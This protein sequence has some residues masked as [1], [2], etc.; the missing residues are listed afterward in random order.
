MGSDGTW[1]YGKNVEVC[2]VPAAPHLPHP[3][4]GVDSAVISSILIRM[5]FFGS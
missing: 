5:V 4:G 3:V 1:E 2:L